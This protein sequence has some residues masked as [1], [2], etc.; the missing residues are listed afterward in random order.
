[1]K[2]R[3][4]LRAPRLS[5]ELER[6]FDRARRFARRHHASLSQSYLALIRRLEQHPANESGSDKTW[7]FEAERRFDAVFAKAEWQ[8]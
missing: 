3:P 5:P 8:R 6:G 4:G 1:M 2:R 7:T